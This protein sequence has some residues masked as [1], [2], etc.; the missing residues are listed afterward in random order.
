MTIRNGNPSTDQGTQYGGGIFND[1][2]TLTVSN[3]TFS[4]NSADM[5]GAI[6]SNYILTV[7]NSTF[8]GNAAGWGGGI[9]TYGGS[10]TVIDSTFSGNSTVNNGGGIEIYGSAT[11]TVTGSIFSG[12]SAQS[13]G[14]GIHDYL[15]TV[16]VAAA[17][18]PII[19]RPTVVAWTSMHIIPR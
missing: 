4:D 18:S 11:V 2:G 8:S 17:P 6:Y 14:G 19:Q 7:L 12:N 16:T 10:L 3:T 9:N 13:L 5:G 15:G 1:G